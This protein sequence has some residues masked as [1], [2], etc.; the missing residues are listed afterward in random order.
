GSRR[1]LAAAVWA[2]AVHPAARTPVPDRSRARPCHPRAL[3]LAPPA[4]AARRAL[5]AD[6]R[7]P[8]RPASPPPRRPGAP[9]PPRPP[10][11]AAPAAVA[12][13]Q[14]RRIAPLDARPAVLVED[15]A[16]HAHAARG[17][18]L[19][20]RREALQG[21]ARDRR[22]EAAVVGGERQEAGERRAHDGRHLA[23]DG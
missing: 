15:R 4:P 1:A 3:G 19:L 20:R 16:V 12:P 17:V 6:R 8:R 13:L 2:R 7:R 5:P 22:D 21:V 10:P 23:L 9:A 11:P 14:A 18:G